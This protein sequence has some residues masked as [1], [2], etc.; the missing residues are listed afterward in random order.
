MNSGASGLRRLFNATRYSLRGIRSTFAQEPAF[1]QE[2]VLV[3][4]LFAAS[5]WLQTSVTEWLILIMPLFILLIVELVNSAIESA[6]DR[7][8]DAPHT[9]SGQAKDM[10][11]AAVFLALLMIAVVWGVFVWMRLHG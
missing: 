11:S 4:I 6:I 10:A 1:R 8:S 3:G 9:L 7:I 2:L 5:F